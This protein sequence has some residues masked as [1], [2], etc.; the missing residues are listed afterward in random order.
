MV[1]YQPKKKGPVL[2]LTDLC[3]QWTGLREGR[4]GWGSGEESG[5]DRHASR[6]VVGGDAS[7]ASKS[8]VS[9][10]VVPVGRGL[11]A[12]WTCVWGGPGR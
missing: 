11:D 2:A 5:R 8:L 1:A 3:P 6:A 12:R 7:G 9:A 4:G 10:A